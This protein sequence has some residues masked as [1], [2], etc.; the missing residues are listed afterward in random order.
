MINVHHGHCI[1]VLRTLEAGSVQCCV[2]SPPYWGLRD[3]GIAPVEWEPVT[4]APMPGLP[5]ITIPAMTCVLGL[6][7]TLEAFIGH[8]VAVFREVRRV[9]HDSGTLWC[10]MGDAYASSPGQHKQSDTAGSKQ[11][12]NRGSM[13][14]VSLNAEGLKPKD[15]Q[16]QPWRVAFALQAAGW[17][18]RSDIIWHK[19]NPMPESTKDRPTKA[20]EYLFLLTKSKSY[21]YDHVAIQEPA[22]ENTI[23]R[24]SKAAAAALGVDPRSSELAM[25]NGWENADSY[26]GQ[27]PTKTMK[28]PTGLDK[29][30]GSHGTIHKEGRRRKTA[31]PG[32]GTK[33]N[34]SMDA[35]LAV[36]PLVRNKRDV[37]TIGTEGYAGAH[38]ATFPTALVEPCLLA[39]TSAKG[40][41]WDCGAPW[42]RELCK[43]EVVDPTHL[44][45][46]FTK[47]KTGS[48]PT[49]GAERTQD[50][51]RTLTVPV[52]WRPTCDCGLTPVPCTVLDPFGGSGTTG[53][54]A[55]SLGLDCILI[56][57]GSHHLPLIHERTQ[58]HVTHQP[59]LPL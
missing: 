9:L 35:A 54:V 46:S 39:G 58:Q 8:I 36:M 56:E 19:P 23:A 30:K 51:P 21:F 5:Q 17:Y 20:H 26:H 38:F 48:R 43:T 3:Y 18:L 15:L 50:A 10:N 57:I 47:G 24:I 29:G 32:S 16:G 42:E 12:S 59:P 52:G 14:R 44:G 37:W 22:S 31:E 4:Y 49:A 7:P 41:C 33:N 25:P 2:T 1:D 13:G 45:S 53:K 11:T 34:S 6:E 40:G 28:A 55:A 27:T